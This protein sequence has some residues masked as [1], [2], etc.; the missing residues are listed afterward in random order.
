[1][2]LACSLFALVVLTG[3]VGCAWVP[4][5]DAGEE[6]QLVANTEVT[7]CK[8]VGNTR[9]AV[10][11]NIWFVPRQESVVDRELAT[12]ARNEGAKLGGNTVTALPSRQ[13]GERDF[14][15]YRCDD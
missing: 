7:G 15:V 3:S 5:S 13:E 4:L 6:V 12:L 1:M 2:R 14:A 8:R 10:L 11:R 9:A